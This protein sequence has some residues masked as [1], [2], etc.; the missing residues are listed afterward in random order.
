MGMPENKKKTV[1]EFAGGLKD[2]VIKVGGRIVYSGERESK[3]G[4]NKSKKV[5]LGKAQMAIVSQF[6]SCVYSIPALK[7]IWGKARFRKTDRASV[8]LHVDERKE[9]GKAKAYNKIVSANRRGLT[10]DLRPNS[11]N[12]IIPKTGKELA[13]CKAVLKYEGISLKNDY[14]E[15]FF[16]YPYAKRKMTPV[17][18]ICPFDPKRKSEL[19]FE[20]ISKWYDITE[21]TPWECDE[22]FFRFDEADVK[23]MS[24]YKNCISYFAF[25][26]ESNS[27]KKTKWYEFGSEEFSL[28][29]YPDK[30]IVFRKDKPVEREN[31]RFY[32]HRPPKA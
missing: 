5:E 32:L 14:P 29:G 6:A 19:K 11:K 3:K 1:V 16:L 8:N 28:K 15:D 27:G 12:I 17:G 31:E 22:F 2:L 9:S 20:M 24:K 26:E 30:E 21:F 13:R 7:Y 18:I 4:T 23:I 10:I 25:V